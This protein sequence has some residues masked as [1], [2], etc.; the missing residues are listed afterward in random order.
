MSILAFVVAAA[1]TQPVTPGGSTPPGPIVP[2]PAPESLLT[3]WPAA[4][5]TGYLAQEQALM[6]IMGPS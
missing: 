5:R 6:A 4:D 1:I 2:A 3:S